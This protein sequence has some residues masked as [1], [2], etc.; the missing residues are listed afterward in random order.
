MG[1]SNYPYGVATDAAG[2]G[3]FNSP[4][5][6]A[7]DATGDVY[8]TDSGNHRIQEFSLALTP[9]NATTWGRLKQLYR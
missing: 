9:A 8:I 6:V 1:S 2:D 3:L 7:T 5:G 4:L